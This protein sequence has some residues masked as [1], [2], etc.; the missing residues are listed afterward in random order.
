MR[1]ILISA[2][3]CEPYK[4]SEQAVG[5]N[6]VLELAKYNQLHVVTRANNQKSIEKFLK[7]RN[8]LNLKF[9]YY[10]TPKIFLSLKNKEKGVY[11]Y[12][13]LWQIGIIALCLKLNKKYHFD[14]AYHVTF[15]SIW[16]PT[17]LYL[18]PCNFIWGPLGGGEAIPKTFVRTL[19]LKGKLLQYLRSILIHSVFLNPLVMIPALKSKAILCRTNDTVSVFPRPL[20][21]KC[22]IL[23]DGSIEPEIFLYKKEN[24]MRDYIHLITTS[25]LIHTKNV[26]TIIKS[27]SLIPKKYYIKLTIVGSGQESN[28]LR[29]LSEDLNVINKISFVKFMPREDVLHILT[30]AD[31]YL[32]A[33]LKE[34]CNLSLLEAMAVGLPVICL[35]WSGMAISTDDSCAIRLPVTNPEQMPKDMAKAIIKLIENPDLRQ[36][37]GEASRKRIQEVFN[38]ESK[39]TFMEELFEELEQ[40][41]EKRHE[42]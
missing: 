18:V 3:S 28:R 24:T 5:W 9:Y 33:S 42:S 10:D 12:Y 6:I 37:M 36:Q 31:I 21:K 13:V 38:W 41:N 22:H 23:T 2:Y 34:A 11:F 35:N 27:L 7:N 30:E 39:G 19:S 14:H 20:Q 4:G 15:G 17:F 16:L 1:R 8:D 29:I 40:G 32:F 26:S 25:R